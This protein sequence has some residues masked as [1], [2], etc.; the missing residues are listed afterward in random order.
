M[1][2]AH[3]TAMAHSVRL[4]IIV[5]NVPSRTGVDIPV[6]VYRRLSRIPNIAGIKEAS[7]SISKIAKILSQCDDLPVYSGNDDM[8]TPIMSLGGK[9]VISVLSN[10][11]PIHT[12]ALTQ[13]ALSG[14]FDTAGALQCSL[15]PLI[16][17]LFSQVNPIPVKAALMLQGYDCGGC[18]LPL[19]EA[20]E[21]IKKKLSE[22]LRLL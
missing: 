22:L 16:E 12:Q 2:F 10:V 17:A 6:S 9:G 7:N 1:H 15:I 11:A 19:T 3:F 20:S 8:I 5:Y 14:D 21:D 13:A 4:P 18:R